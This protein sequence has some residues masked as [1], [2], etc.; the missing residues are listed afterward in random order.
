MAKAGIR[1]VHA[2]VFMSPQMARDSVGFMLVSG[3]TAV[4]DAVHE[5]LKPM[6]GEVWLLGEDPDRAAAYKLFGNSMLFVIA[7]GI[8][9]VFA[10][11]K[12]IGL[13]ATEALDVFSKFQPGGIIKSRGAKM[14]RGDFSASFELTMARKDIRLMIEAAGSQPM[15]VLPGIAKRMDEAIAK[16]HGA[17]D[18]GAIAA[19]VI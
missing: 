15:T 3:P 9:D 16:G 8:T 2:P 6:T 5:A 17:E 7:A 1:F 14:A 11:A 18:L 13:S 19:E 10:M 4:V 12:G